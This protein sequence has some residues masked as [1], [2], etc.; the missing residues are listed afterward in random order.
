MFQSSIEYETAFLKH[1]NLSRA[2]N[3][4]DKGIEYLEMWQSGPKDAKTTVYRCY[5]PHYKDISC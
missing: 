1:T 5:R 3:P 2:S 4:L